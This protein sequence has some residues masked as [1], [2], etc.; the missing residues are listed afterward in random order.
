MIVCLG[1]PVS[2][3]RFTVSGFGSGIREEDRGVVCGAGR[4]SLS[5]NSTFSTLFPIR[6]SIDQ[7]V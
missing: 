5:P 4:V 1:D 3:N 7:F 6:S 2:A